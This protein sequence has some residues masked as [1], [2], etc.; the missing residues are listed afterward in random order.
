MPGKLVECELCSMLAVAQLDEEVPR[1]KQVT[2]FHQ[3]PLD[4]N[5][6]F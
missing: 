2:F 6:H 5:R 1:E 4:I 3:K